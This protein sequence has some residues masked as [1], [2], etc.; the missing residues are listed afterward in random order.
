MTSYVTHS[1][2]I[3]LKIFR[4][5]RFVPRQR[6]FQV[7]KCITRYTKRRLFDVMWETVESSLRSQWTMT[8]VNP[9]H[10]TFNSLF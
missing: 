1:I 3:L 8:G 7:S 9:A 2:I 5:H 10:V 4:D 6:L